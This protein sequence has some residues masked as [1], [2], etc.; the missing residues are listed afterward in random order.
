MTTMIL[1]NVL[2]VAVLACLIKPGL[3]ARYTGGEPWPRWIFLVVL[4]VLSYLSPYGPQQEVQQVQN[5]PSTP[6]DT[7][8]SV[9]EAAAAT[10]P[11][12]VAA[13]IP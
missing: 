1:F 4:L 10:T 11:V 2:L 13:E 6:V 8:P 5:R 12:E 7:G 3:L 9:V